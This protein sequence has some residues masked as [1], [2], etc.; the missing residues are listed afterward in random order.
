MKSSAKVPA[1]ATII[2]AEMEPGRGPTATVIVKMG[3]L[4][5]G[6]AFLCGLQWGKVKSLINDLGK[7]VKE[8]GPATPVKILG[9]DGLPKAGDELS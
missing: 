5:V 9:F 4:K 8:A 1:R 7:P 6:Q 3:T 2:E